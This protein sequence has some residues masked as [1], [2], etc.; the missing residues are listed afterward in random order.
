VDA[1][2]VMRR[3][4]KEPVQTEAKKGKRFPKKIFGE[5]VV[6]KKTIPPTA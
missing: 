6:A 3:R 1:V 2:E 4:A 5:G